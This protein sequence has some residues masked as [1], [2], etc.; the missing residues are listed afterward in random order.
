MRTLFLLFVFTCFFYTS[1]AQWTQL[2]T[3]GYSSYEAYNSVI[4]FHPASY[5]PYVMF[6]DIE[7]NV[8][9]T[10]KM[11]R[12]DGTAW[13]IVGSETLED[14]ILINN[15]VAFGFDPINANV[16]IAYFHT[17]YQTG[18][19]SQSGNSWLPMLGLD[20][21]IIDPDNGFDFDLDDVGNPTL[22]Y[23]SPECTIPDLAITGPLSVLI[24]N[25]QEWGYLVAPCQSAMPA[26][27]PS[28][29]YNDFDGK[30]MVFHSG[31]PDPDENNIG[32][33]WLLEYNI[34][35]TEPIAIPE[36][37]SETSIGQMTTNPVNGETYVYTIEPPTVGS[38]D[39]VL[40]LM[41]WDGTEL[42]VINTDD[43]SIKQAAAFLKVHPITGE[44]YV[45]YRDADL[46]TGFEFEWNVK[47]LEGSNWVAPF[48]SMEPL[49]NFEVSDFSFHPVTGD[50]HIAIQRFIDGP[51]RGAVITHE[52][53]S[54]VDDREVKVSLTL[55]P[56]PSSDVLNIDLQGVM[57]PYM[58]QVFSL[59]GRLVLERSQTN[60]EVG[61]LDISG[62]Q[63]GSYELTCTGD[64]GRVQSTFVK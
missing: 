56:N 32:E 49:E 51:L 4:K 64:F 30:L 7:I 26:T 34:S 31:G 38:P 41:K 54:S 28:L 63:T 29:E 9:S 13:Q 58:I 45:V 59:D 60:S 46:Y 55:F 50:I 14:L 33:R 37:I 27:T 40:T 24:H 21:Y 53:A 48:S 20:N 16:P 8:S 15:H 3:E 61:Q 35:T 43:I 1:P 57:T 25:S 42:S 19:V 23:G 62:L 5:E 18:V 47:R 44:I 6:Q 36:F 52:Q 11:R 39:Q 17:G 22:A 12:F 10:I 2:S